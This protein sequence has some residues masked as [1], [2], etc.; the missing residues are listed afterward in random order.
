MKM[1]RLLLLTLALAIGGMSSAYA[2]D[3]FGL[4]L[5]IGIPG[6]YAEPPVVY[7]APPPAV[8]YTPAP[9]RYYYAPRAEFYYSEPRHY[10]RRHHDWNDRYDRHERHEHRHHG[11]R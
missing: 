4:S 3:S 2:R 10:H 8:Y 7:Y 11:Y 1:F 9:T 6:Y 5:N